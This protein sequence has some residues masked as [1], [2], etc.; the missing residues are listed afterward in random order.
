MN[1]T[2]EEHIT[3]C[4]LRALEYVDAGDA[5]HAI[6]SMM[7]D[8]R[9]H[10]ETENHVGVILGMHLMTGGFLQSITDVRKWIEGFN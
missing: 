7:S 9:K 6:A 4:R 3:W 1:K 2:R 10:P 5:E 8:I